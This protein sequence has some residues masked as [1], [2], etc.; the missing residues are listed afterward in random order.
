MREF[1]YYLSIKQLYISAIKSK[2][3]REYDISQRF[4]LVV[5]NVLL[6]FIYMFSCE[7]I[8]KAFIVVIVS[9]H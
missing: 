2:P 8:D 5:M 9:S 6:F 4:L 1:D 3:L 7:L